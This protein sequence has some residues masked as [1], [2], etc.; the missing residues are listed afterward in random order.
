MEEDGA[1]NPANALVFH[2][3]ACGRCLSEGQDGGALGDRIKSS[4]TVF[5]Q[6]ERYMSAVVLVAGLLMATAQTR[7]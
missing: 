2:V 1:G 3:E 7:S 6:T 5:L 4:L